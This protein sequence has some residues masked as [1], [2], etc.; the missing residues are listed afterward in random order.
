M[1]RGY[2]LCPY[3]RVEGTPCRNAPESRS[4]PQSLAALV[5]AR[6]GR[7]EELEFSRLEAGTNQTRKQTRS[8]FDRRNRNSRQR[9]AVWRLQFWGLFGIPDHDRV[10]PQQ[11]TVGFGVLQSFQLGSRRWAVREADHPFRVFLHLLIYL[12]LCLF[13]V[14]RSG[15]HSF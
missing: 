4:V 7:S 3:P 13:R 15:A 10:L 8:K 5:F 2:L 6:P 11:A 12:G 9:L 1:E 14:P